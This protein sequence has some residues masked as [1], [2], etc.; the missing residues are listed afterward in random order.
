RRG[1]KH[2]KTFQNFYNT[3]KEKSEMTPYNWEEAKLYLEALVDSKFFSSPEKAINLAKEAKDELEVIYAAI[4]FEKDTLLFFYQILEMIKSQELVK[5]I[6]E[7][8]KKHI[9]R[10][11][12]MK[13]KLS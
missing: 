7:Q 2:L 6:I 8:E 1:R 5:K 3:L 12:T 4:D 9:L 13:S 11:S 10:L